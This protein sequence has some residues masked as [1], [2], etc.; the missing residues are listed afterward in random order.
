MRPDRDILGFIGCV[1]ILVG[2][3]EDDRGTY[4]W[5]FSGGL[6]LV[7]YAA[8]SARIEKRRERNR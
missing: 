8:V 4:G 7:I 5:V 2:L 6:L 3:F 1:L